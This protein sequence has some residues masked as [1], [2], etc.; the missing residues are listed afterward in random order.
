MARLG[1][2]ILN[3]QGEERGRANGDDQIVMVYKGLYEPGDRIVFETDE[4]DA[5]YVIRVDG[6]MDESYVY[7]TKNTVGYI[8]PFDEKKISYNPASFTGERHYIT[9][10]KAR[11]YEN[12]AYRNL[13]ENVMDQHGDTGC[14][15]HAHAN[16]ETRGE[17]VFAA[18]NAI[19]GVVSV[20]V[21]K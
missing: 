20:R 11:E 3:G 16:V 19:D 14:Y 5:Y 21:S 2:R 6:A 9:V 10:R 18:R 12:R 1:I 13:A 15:P 8:I 17:S 4:T 7:L